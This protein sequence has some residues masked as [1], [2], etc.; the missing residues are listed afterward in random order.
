MEEPNFHLATQIRV[1]PLLATPL[2]GV[3]VLLQN[4]A[5]VIGAHLFNKAVHKVEQPHIV[6]QQFSAILCILEV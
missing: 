2:P 3:G 4:E 6:G 1:Q 5:S